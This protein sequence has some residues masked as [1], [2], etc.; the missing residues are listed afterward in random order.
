MEEDEEVERGRRRQGV[1]CR[2]GMEGGT[3][4][5]RKEEGR[6]EET[7]KKR[8]EAEGSRGEVGFGLER[9]KSPG[10]PFLGERSSWRGR[11]ERIGERIGERNAMEYSRGEGLSIDEKSSI[12]SSSFRY[13]YE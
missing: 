3:E 9:W 12:F 10:A 4:E 6:T 11:G 13:N 8:E 2:E 5:G 1:G 7:K